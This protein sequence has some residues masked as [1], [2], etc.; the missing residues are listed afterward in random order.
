M[1]TGLRVLVLAGVLAGA[2]RLAQAPDV[3]SLARAAIGSIY[4]TT[5][6]PG[7]KDRVRVVR[8]TWGVP[9]IYASST[10]DLFCA[11]G[12]VTAQDRLWQMEMWRRA[13]EGRLSEVFGSSMLAR[14]RRA[15]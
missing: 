10:D 7:L 2:L 4:G 3:E 5:A 14:D 15:R 12:Y 11:Q 1:R 13:A 6:L 8:H 9:H